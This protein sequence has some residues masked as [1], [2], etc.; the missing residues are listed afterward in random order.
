[1][2]IERTPLP[3]EAVGAFRPLRATSDGLSLDDRAVNCG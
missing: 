2:V 1:M 3:F